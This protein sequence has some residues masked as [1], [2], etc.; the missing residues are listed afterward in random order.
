M[1]KLFNRK[2][3][4]NVVKQRIPTIGNKN[5]PIG[6]EAIRRAVAKK[7]SIQSN[8]FSRNHPKTTLKSK[9]KKTA[10]GATLAGAL[11]GLIGVSVEKSKIANISNINASKKASVT[12]TQIG[13]SKYKNRYPLVS[14]KQFAKEM[15]QVSKIIRLNPKNAVDA[16]IATNII[17]IAKGTGV[18]P[19]VALRTIARTSSSFKSFNYRIIELK[20]ELAL[21]EE[22]NYLEHA[23][24]INFE[25]QKIEKIQSI[26]REVEGLTP[27]MREELVNR[28][29][30]Y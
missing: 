24:A 26:V 15:K 7:N 19:R 16:R 2:K 6:K 11:V 20:R 3:A 27:S 4:S 10:V 5:N 23:N 13:S 25:L 1:V 29:K 17:N 22:K 9:L 18:S 8:S 30:K 14:E 21:A 28:V 12:Q